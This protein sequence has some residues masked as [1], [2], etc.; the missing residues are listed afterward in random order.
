MLLRALALATLA[1]AWVACKQPIAPQLGLET[2]E[3]PDLSTIEEVARQ[4]IDRERRRLDDLLATSDDPVELARAF[5]ALGELYHAYELNTPATACYRNAATIDGESFLWP[6][7]LGV[8]QAAEGDPG[9]S[10]KQL[11]QALT[12]KG[13]DSARLHLANTLTALGETDAARTLF[14]TLSQTSGFEAAAN[15]GLGRLHLDG[16]DAAAAIERF[17]ATLEAQPEAGVV[18]HAL[19]LAHRQQGDLDRAT[20]LLSG[21]NSGE[22][23]FPDPAL[24]RVSELAISSGALL[25]RGNRALVA[26]ELARA[27]RLFEQAIEANAESS[28]AYRNLALTLAQLQ[29][30]DRALEVLEDAAQRFPDNVWI[31]FDLGSTQMGRAQPEAAVEAFEQAIALDPN[32]ARAHF[33]LANALIA[34]QR[35]SDATPHLQ[36]VLA[37]EP[38]NPRARYLMAMSLHEQGQSDQAVHRLEKLLEDDPDNLVARRGLAEVLVDQRRLPRAMAVFEQGLVRDLSLDDQVQLLNQ[39]AEVSW[40]SGRRD[41]A[42]TAW[43]RAVRAAPESSVAHTALANGLQLIGRRADA[44]DHFAHAVDLDPK[45][46]TAWLSEASLWILDQEVRTARDRLEQALEHVPDNPGLVHTLAR[47]LAT[48][49]DVQVRD[50]ARALELARAAYNLE[51]NLDHAETLA[52]ALAENDQYEE[53]IQWQRRLITQLGPSANRNVLQRLVGNLRRYENRQPVRVQ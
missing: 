29:E 39:L 23:V 51:R 27:V 47:L 52:M 44:R 45:N 18:R 40:R 46:A 26:G 38:D 11:E 31:H 7:Y 37:L 22:V 41:Q 21:E 2:V 3:H 4:Q 15:Y 33:N 8:L 35:W 30:M 25:K 43:E 24:D 12:L 48:S 28:E 36:R 9:G 34:L 14:E 1:L 13:D 53:A 49:A 19:G 42:I 10:R 32:L 16:G 17:E 5:G 20:E 50:G 6:Y